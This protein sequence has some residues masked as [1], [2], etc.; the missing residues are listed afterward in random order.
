L[1]TTDTAVPPGAETALLPTSKIQVH[2]NPRKTVDDDSQNAL[3]ESVRLHGIITPITVRRSED[4]EGW[5]LLAGQRRLLAALTVGLEDIPAVVLDDVDG[6]REQAIGMVENLHRDPLKPM[7]EAAAFKQASA[8]L[9]PAQIAAAYSVSESLVRDRIALLDLPESLHQYVDSGQVPIQATRVIAK[10]AAHSQKMAEVCAEAAIAGVT[11]I[12]QF[13][14][15]PPWAISTAVRHWNTEHPDDQVLAYNVTDREI[16][17]DKIPW[18]DE[19]RDELRDRAQKVIDG[20]MWVP[21]LNAADIV[22]ARS[23]GALLEVESVDGD[24]SAFITDPEWLFEY[25]GPALDRRVADI[26]QQKTSQRERSEA[27][28]GTFRKKKKSEMNEAELAEYEEQRAADKRAKDEAFADNDKLGANLLGKFKPKMDKQTMLTLALLIGEKWAE[29][30]GKGVRY[31]VPEL[32]TVTEKKTGGVRA[33][34]VSAAEGYEWWLKRLKRLKTP[35]EILHHVLFGIAAAEFCDEKVVA[36][37]QR[38]Y[39]SPAGYAGEGAVAKN[40]L[41][42]TRASL[43]PRMKAT[44][45]ARQKQHEEDVKTAKEWAA[46]PAGVDPLDPDD[47]EEFETL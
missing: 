30:I 40:L 15:N 35:D 39:A 23:F 14:T 20:Y 11:P 16:H 28:P 17:V 2:S 1:S 26:E 29:T 33:E 18:T 38:L 3:V 22:A 45:I 43:P 42:I 34:Y 24:D 32:R 7:E 4:G 46:N 12:G 36:Q 37:S 44:A 8:T 6:D 31:T 13:S 27:R 21:L 9:T 25:A 41:A 5:V 19:Q 10:I 47:D